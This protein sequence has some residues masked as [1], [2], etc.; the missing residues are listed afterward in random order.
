MGQKFGERTHGQEQK[1][2]SQLFLS[3]KSIYFFT[4]DK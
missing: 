1:L 4:V 2:E 3:F